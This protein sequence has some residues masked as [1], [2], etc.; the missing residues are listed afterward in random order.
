VPPGH[1]RCRRRPPLPSPEEVERIQAKFG[2]P[3]RYRRRTAEE[4]REGIRIYAREHLRQ[5]ERPDQRAYMAACKL[6]A[7]LVWPSK[8]KGVTGKTFT[9]LCADEGL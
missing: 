3:R 4:A 7:R 8:L 1:G 5:G 6:D 2:G 9:E